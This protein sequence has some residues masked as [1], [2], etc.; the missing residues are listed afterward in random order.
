MQGIGEWPIP[1]S[2]FDMGGKLVLALQSSTE[3][4][5]FEGNYYYAMICGNLS[6]QLQ[7]KQKPSSQ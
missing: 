5:N 6:T 3:A 1:V 7:V 4:F 2:Y